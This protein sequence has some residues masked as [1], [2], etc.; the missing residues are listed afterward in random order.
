MQLLELSKE[1]QLLLKM[2]EVSM[3]EG[4]EGIK[5]IIKLFY[6]N[7]NIDKKENGAK[8]PFLSAYFF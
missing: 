7:V 6:P 2:T 1:V 5:N 8:A 3:Y 4:L